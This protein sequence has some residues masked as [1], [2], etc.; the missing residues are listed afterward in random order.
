M[1]SLDPAKNGWQAIYLYGQLA[2][3]WTTSIKYTS[4]EGAERFASG[5]WELGYSLEGRAVIDVWQIPSKKESELTGNTIES[6]LCV[7]IYDPM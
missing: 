1:R 5:E 6:G 3:K 7:R 4:I 2:G